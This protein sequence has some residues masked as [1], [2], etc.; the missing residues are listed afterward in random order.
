MSAAG[1]QRFVACYKWVLDEADIRIADD[2]SV[3]FSHAKGKLSEFDRSAIEAAMQS[4]EAAGGEES[5]IE[6]HSLT[7]GNAEVLRSFKD[8]LSRG[9]IE[10][11]AI[12]SSAGDAADG[13]V[14][15]Q[16]L[17]AGIK[18]MGDVSCV[19]AAEGASDTYARQVPARIAALLDWPFVSSVLELR[20]EDGVLFATR[21]LDDCLQKVQVHLPAVVSVLPEGFEPRTPGLKAVMAAGRKPTHELDASELGF[22]PSNAASDLL[23]PKR[24]EVSQIGYVA[25]RKKIIFKDMS[26]E[27]AANAVATELRKE[28]VV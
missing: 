12:A 1:L 22:C 28:G 24:C 9:P 19:F 5:G 27:E 25:S 21:K 3:D 4:Y 26:A 6:V 16:A 20:I 11:W 2:L 7:F 23:T 10:G 8:A 15:A 14:T 17:A 18:A 13:R